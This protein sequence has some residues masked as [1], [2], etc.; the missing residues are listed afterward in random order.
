[1]STSPNKNLDQERREYRRGNLEEGAL[2]DHPTDLFKRWME[3]ARSTANPDPTAMTLSTVGPE[4]NPSSRMVLLKAIREGK[5]IFFSNYMSRKGRELETN[6]RV[7]LHFYWPELE[8]QVRIE[9]KA[10][11][12]PEADSDQYFRSRPY[13]SQVGAWASPQSRVIPD[14]RYLETEFEKYHRKF[15]RGTNVPRPP[16]WGGYEITPFRVEFWQGGVHRLHDRIEYRMEG[17]S[18]SRSRLAP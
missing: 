15:P 14:R 17:N 11:P 18:W 4:G 16:H 7:A 1:M 8:R 9:G 13:E 2:P 3:E 5:L 10:A 6:T 12:L